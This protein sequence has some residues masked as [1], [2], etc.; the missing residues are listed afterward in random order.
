MNR[1]LCLPKIFAFIVLMVFTFSLVGNATLIQLD[2]AHKGRAYG[3][4]DSFDIARQISLDDQGFLYIAG[5]STPRNDQ[6]DPW[7][8][9]EAGELT[10][11]TDVFVAKLSP[12]GEL[13]WVRRTGSEEDETLGGMV[14]VKN[15][16]YICGSTYGSYGGAVNGSADVYVVKLMTDG[17]LAWR[18]PFQFGSEGEDLCFSI[19]VGDA[20]YIAGSTSGTLFGSLEPS[21]GTVHQFVARLDE[22]DGD[23]ANL[24]LVRGRQRSGLSSSSVDIA[25]IARDNLYYLSVNW[26]ATANLVERATSYLNIADLGTVL[27]QQLRVLAIDGTNSF[28][29]MDMDVVNETG[30][31]YV[32]GIST[33]EDG[34]EGY[35]ALRLN[36]LSTSNNRGIEWSSFLGYRSREVPLDLQ[37]P[38]IIADEAN[39]RV[40][41]MGTEEG[42]FIREH[43]QSG[44]VLTPFLKL[45]ADT[46]VV[47]ERWDRSVDIRN[48]KQEILDIVMNANGEIFYTGVWDTGKSLPPYALVGSVGSPKF[49]SKLD[50][51]EPVTGSIE[52]KSNV[53]TGGVPPSRGPSIVRWLLIICLLI[54][55]LLNLIYFCTRRRQLSGHELFE[56]NNI[57]AAYKVENR[58]STRSI[59][60]VTSGRSWHGTE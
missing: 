4:P 57:G 23:A 2:H 10:G 16:I 12:E 17:K 34:H 1:S 39:N 56:E 15:G 9:T 13:L 55:I 46:G 24:D 48:C 40:F 11:K 60:R 29:A 51:E 30:N 43:S 14:I 45:T 52:L 47:V 5:T 37:Q 28:R 25:K 53:R 59:Y 27:M 6:Q 33:L 19:T 58:A 38:R 42:L 54:G 31:V 44:I 3:S 49:T 35:Y 32:M 18:R 50:V 21:K 8:D 20:V 22:K 7:G 41:V 26:N 36:T